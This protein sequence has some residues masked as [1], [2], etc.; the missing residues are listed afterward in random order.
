M[1]G[2]MGN[3]RGKV[4]RQHDDCGVEFST[5]SWHDHVI[6]LIGAAEY[7][8]RSAFKAQPAQTTVAEKGIDVMNPS[9]L[10]ATTPPTAAPP[11][12]TS[13]R[14]RRPF[15]LH[16]IL[17]L[18]TLQGVIG[19]LATSAFGLWL[20]LLPGEVWA[21]SLLELFKILEPIAVLLGALIVAV[22]L[23]R[24]RG[25]GW[26][27]MMLLLAYWMATGLVEY[28]TG[29]PDYIAMVLNVMMAFYL[30][31]REVRDLFTATIARG[32]SA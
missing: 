22:G 7:S 4:L 26:Y 24:Y 9:H 13:Q 15:G 23:W 27:G 11:A 10:D 21:R 18:L 3:K 28:F 25:W 6:I 12:A 32:V 29:S 31:Q 30:N 14:R 19:V 17:I 8:N 2:I 20:V 1:V 5:T 16:M